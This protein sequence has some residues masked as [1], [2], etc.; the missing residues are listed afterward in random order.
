MIV[1]F[2]SWVTLWAVTIP[3][4]LTLATSRFE[5]DHTTVYWSKFSTTAVNKVSVF[6]SIEALPFTEIEAL[7]WMIWSGPHDDNATTGPIIKIDANNNLFFIK[8]S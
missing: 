6:I 8:T 1:T 2:V 7:F 3:D 4:W 5:E